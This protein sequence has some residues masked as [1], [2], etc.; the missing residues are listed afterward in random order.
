MILVLVLYLSV[1]LI[2]IYTQWIVKPELVQSLISDY[3]FYSWDHLAIFILI[4]NYSLLAGSLYALGKTRGNGDLNLPLGGVIAASSLGSALS[5]LFNFSVLW[6]AITPKYF[7]LI[8][9]AIYAVN[10]L[11]PLAVF[12]LKKSEPATESI[13][14]KRQE[15]IAGTRKILAQSELLL[16]QSKSNPHDLE[17]LGKKLDGQDLDNKQIIEILDQLLIA[18]KGLPE[19]RL[20]SIDV[21]RLRLRARGA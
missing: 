1:L 3:P 21:D 4:I 18:T 20:I 15:L 14:Y 9:L 16:V 6:S 8:I 7:T 5:F 10:V 17:V 11:I 2:T 12:S 13:D 19:S